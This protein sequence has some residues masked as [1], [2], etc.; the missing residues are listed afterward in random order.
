MEVG[1][2]YSSRMCGCCGH[3]KP[4]SFADKEYNCDSC[5]FKSDRDLNAARNILIMN[6]KCA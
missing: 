3:L 2:S 4:Q 5:G 1:E 6:T